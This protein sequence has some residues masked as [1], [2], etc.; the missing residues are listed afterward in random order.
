[1]IYTIALGQFEYKVMAQF[2]MLSI[3]QNTNF[4]G[5][6]IVLTDT[7]ELTSDINILAPQV[8]VVNIFKRF[9]NLKDSIKS[10]FN[11]FCLK[12]LISQ[13]LDIKQ[14]GYVLYVDCDVLI[15]YPHFNEL[16]GFWESCG[17]IQGSPNGKW[18]IGR[19]VCNTGSDVLTEDEKKQH[20]SFGVCA[21]VVGFP[22]NELGENFCK[23]WWQ[24]NT[25]RDFSLDDQGNLTALLVRKYL[26]KFKY[27][28]FINTN[29]WKLENI[30]HFHTHRKKG[31]W[32][33]V[34]FLLRKYE[35]QENKHLGKWQM[36]KPSENI[37]N[38]WEFT[39][40]MVFVDNPSITG[41]IQH[42][43]LG[44]YIWWHNIQGFEKVKFAGDNLVYGD[45]F[46]GGENSFTLSKI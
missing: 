13:I 1:M 38:I 19:N 5:D 22:G 44:T 12:P 26:D 37:S 14:Y 10:R 15:N 8:K 29:Q 32:E 28:D 3:V 25:V 34:K 39:E 20:A 11:I 2:L 43:N 4:N 36:S 40:T 21:G 23:D 27:M 30:T 16:F 42:T 41:Q 33:C 17:H 46:R 35:I 7:D 31:F 6:L 18:N 45:S 9:S 24:Y